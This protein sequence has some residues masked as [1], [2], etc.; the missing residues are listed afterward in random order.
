[1]L[2]HGSFITRT[3]KTR[4]IS[5][6]TT[7]LFSSSSTTTTTTDDNKNDLSA[8]VTTPLGKNGAHLLNG[9]DIYQVPSKLDGHPLA[10]YGIQSQPN[11][12]TTTSHNKNNN[13]NNDKQH[14]PAILLL[15]GRT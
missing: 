1:M 5:T 7:R 4:T 15:H 8:F 2:H 13:P 9:L 11:Q 6:S 14:R 10:V 12:L 3:T